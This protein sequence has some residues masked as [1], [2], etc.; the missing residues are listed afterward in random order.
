MGVLGP[1]PGFG[2]EALDFKPR[3]E[4]G[5]RPVVFAR[6]QEA[7]GQSRVGSSATIDDRDVHVVQGTGAGGAIA[8]LY[9]DKASGLL[10]RQ[11]CYALPPVGRIPTQIDYADYRDVSGIKMPFRWTVIWLDGQDTVQL[12]EVRPKSP[13]T[14]R[15][16]P[17]G[18]S[19]FVACLLG[20]TTGAD[21]LT[22]RILHTSRGEEA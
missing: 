5:C 1:S 4:V 6:I 12:N 13:L 20:T 7:L 17:N 22:D 19:T 3:V 2:F 10:V 9:F 16:S 14:P 11:V 8:T 15:S 18:A 21:T